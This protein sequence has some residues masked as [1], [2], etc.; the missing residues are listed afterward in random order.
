MT[1][2]PYTDTTSETLALI[3]DIASKLRDATDGNE[4]HA[5]GLIHGL[6]RGHTTV[7]EARAELTGLTFRHI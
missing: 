4:W 3:G 2:R 5:V 6:A 1:D 7:A